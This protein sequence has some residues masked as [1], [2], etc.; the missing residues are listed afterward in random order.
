MMHINP[1]SGDRIYVDYAGK[2]LSIIDK[3]SGKL[4]EV[5]FFVAIL[6]ASQ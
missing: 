3:E 6:R 2:P 4:K 5:Q 1:K